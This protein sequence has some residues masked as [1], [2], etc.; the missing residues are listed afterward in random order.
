MAMIF[1]A[2]QGDREGG[3]AVKWNDPVWK[4]GHYF[5]FILFI[6]LIFC[7]LFSE[8][9]RERKRER[10]RTERKRNTDFCSTYLCIHWLI[11]VYTLTGDQTC[12]VGVLGR[13]EPTELPSLAI[14]LRSRQTAGFIKTKLTFCKSLLQG[15]HC[16]HA[17]ESQLLHLLAMW[18]WA[19]FPTFTFLPLLGDE[20]YL[21]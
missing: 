8:R 9:E 15:K 18:L 4:S 12:N 21:A 5:Y 11:L 14:I 3:S 6:L 7:F 1:P 10:E 17:T 2:T 20:P 16:E 19:H 13:N